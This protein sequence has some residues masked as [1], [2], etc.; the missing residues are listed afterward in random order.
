MFLSRRDPDDA[1]RAILAT[2]APAMFAPVLTPEDLVDAGVPSWVVPAV[3]AGGLVAPWLAAGT[4][5]RLLCTAGL[6]LAAA[7]W[8]TS[9][10]ALPGL[11][12][13]VLL[14]TIALLAAVWPPEDGSWLGRLAPVPAA[15]LTVLAL[16]GYGW[17]A[18][19][20]GPLGAYAVAGASGVVGLLALRSADPGPER[21]LAWATVLLPAAWSLAVAGGLATQA[22]LPVLGLGPALVLTRAVPPERVWRPVARV[23]AEVLLSSPPRL[24]VS[25]FG[26]LAVVG[27]ALLALPVSDGRGRGL[28]LVDAAFTAVSA[29]TLTGLVT[30]D[31]SALS[32]FGRLVLWGLVQLG[33]LAILTFSGA[34]AAWSSAR[35]GPRQ[36]VIAARLL[37]HDVRHGLLASFRRVAA[38]LL[39]VELGG[40]LLLLPALL[41]AGHRGR[42]LGESV[43]LASSAFCNAGLSPWTGGLAAFARDPWVVVVVTALS[44]L[45]LLGPTV[46]AA[47]PPVARGEP[48]PTWLRLTL[49]GNAVL[50]V[51]PFP[52]L[53]G[54]EWSRA[55][56]ALPGYARVAAAALLS[57]SPRTA[58][59][60]T[61]ELQRA[62]PATRT[63]LE[64]LMFVGGNTGSAAGGVKVSTIA[65]LLVAVVGAARGRRA[66]EFGSRQI[67]PR[68]VYEAVGIVA[69]GIATVVLGLVLLELTQHLPLDTALFEVVSA[70]STS[71]LTAGGVAQVDN[72]GKIVLLGCMFAGRV[73]PLTLFLL[74]TS[75]PEREGATWPSEEVPVG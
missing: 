36:E 34:A 46:L 2:L 60:S 31:P 59:F 38:A 45:G 53:L 37:G 66:L 68:V 67:P 48:I 3:A 8:T 25:S 73:G 50:L 54:L 23:L 29:V 32:S 5:T 17:S 44:L 56:G 69:A 41:A 24:L 33:A 65:V 57:V 13:V 64:L 40:A 4:A 20:V 43:F 61:V 42:A 75:E 35:R 49:V 71:G 10:L 63:L 14:G 21:Q 27:T 6:L 15:A 22:T 19:L 51:V 58:G 28:A 7:G 18:G 1:L 11:G 12:A 47:L 72:V 74:L 70:V 39:A 62:E 16:V 9:H 55:L 52:L 30:T 26:A